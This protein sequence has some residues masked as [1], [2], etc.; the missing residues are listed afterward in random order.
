MVTQRRHFF[1]EET[2]TDMTAQEPFLYLDS[3]GYIGVA[4]QNGNAAT[5]LRISPGE[6]ITL[7]LES[8]QETSET[9]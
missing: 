9:K 2:G 1:A 7:A 6:A 3:A 4:I 5:S 8:G